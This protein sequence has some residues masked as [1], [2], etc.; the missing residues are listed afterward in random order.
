M[1]QWDTELEFY[2]PWL[3]P[4]GMLLWHFAIL[5]GAIDWLGR[6]LLACSVESREEYWGSYTKFTFLLT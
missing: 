3:A 1:A 5:L 6:L 2:Y 4:L